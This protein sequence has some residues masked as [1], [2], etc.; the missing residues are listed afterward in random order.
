[1]GGGGGLK[2]SRWEDWR[3]PSVRRLSRN[4]GMLDISHTYGPPRRVTRITLLYTLLPKYLCFR[5]IRKRIKAKNCYSVYSSLFVKNSDDILP[6]YRRVRHPRVKLRLYLVSTRNICVIWDG[7]IWT[8][9]YAVTLC[10]DCKESIWNCKIRTVS[11][12]WSPWP[13]LWNWSGKLVHNHQRVSAPSP[14]FLWPDL[15]ILI[16]CFDSHGQQHQLQRWCSSAAAS[17]SSDCLSFQPTFLF[18]SSYNISGYM[19]SLSFVS[20]P[21]SQRNTCFRR[22]NVP[23]ILHAKCKGVSV[24]SPLYFP[25]ISTASS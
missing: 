18:C 2:R 21:S 17:H 4:G 5:Y 25:S 15:F 20:A 12:V 19:T 16:I 9:R 8:F 6:K 22:A 14:C 13:M 7:H 24:V 1:M 11:L 3:P 10:S 23:D